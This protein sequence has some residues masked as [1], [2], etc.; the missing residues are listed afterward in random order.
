[1]GLGVLDILSCCYAIDASVSE[2]NSCE[3]ESHKGLITK[4]L[5]VNP[6]E[7]ERVFA[8]AMKYD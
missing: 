6:S 2:S 1:M 3:I 8:Y 5:E 7:R 4:L